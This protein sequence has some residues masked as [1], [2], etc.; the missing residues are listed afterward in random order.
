[1]GPCPGATARGGLTY[2]LGVA[3]CPG[4]VDGAVAAEQARGVVALAALVHHGAGEAQAVAEHHPG[5]AGGPRVSTG[6]HWGPEGRVSH[7]VGSREWPGAPC[8]TGV[9]CGPR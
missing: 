4:A 5:V 6:D 9:P 1:M 2:A 7:R 3:A 8:A